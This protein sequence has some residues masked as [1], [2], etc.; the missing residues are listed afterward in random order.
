M[1]DRPSGLIGCGDLF[2]VS[3]QPPR[4]ILIVRHRCRFYYVPSNFL[5]AEYSGRH[6][7]PVIAH[8]QS[9][10]RD[11][12][13]ALRQAPETLVSK[14]LPASRTSGEYLSPGS[15]WLRDRLCRRSA[16]SF[17][18]HA[19]APHVGGFSRRAPRYVRIEGQVCRGSRRG[20]EKSTLLARAPGTHLAQSGKA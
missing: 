5:S 14:I 7:R 20:R 17:R 10:T 18:W 11:Q 16:T 6:T 15:P 1:Q 19:Y 9:D 12:T 2:S 13:D 8:D 3:M 4:F